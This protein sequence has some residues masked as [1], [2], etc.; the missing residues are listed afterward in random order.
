[1]KK[2]I[3]FI[4]ALLAIAMMVAMV[5]VFAAEATM[6]TV[7]VEIFETEENGFEMVNESSVSVVETQQGTMYSLVELAALAGLDVTMDTG[8][9]TVF[10]SGTYLNRKYDIPCV[11]LNIGEKSYEITKQSVFDGSRITSIT[12]TQTETDMYFT[13]ASM[14]EFFPNVFVTDDGTVRV[15]KA[16]ETYP[17]FVQ[18]S[19]MMNQEEK[20]RV[21]MAMWMLYN[22]YSEGYE[23]VM[24]YAPKITPAT[25]RKVNQMCS[26]NI[27]NA[28]AV[29]MYN[30]STIYWVEDRLENMSMVL[31]AAILCHEATHFA[32][33]KQGDYGERQTV[34]NEG[35]ALYYMGQSGYEAANAEVEKLLASYTDSRNIY[36]VGGNAFRAW[37]AE[38]TAA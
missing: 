23:I 17:K 32:Q 1:M 19:S 14:Y 31:L 38:Q 18:R 37:Y 2:T 25:Q 22:T 24:K 36:T 15:L 33:Y 11:R 13:A 12:W 28:I 4:A 9:S 30:G 34:L 7:A 26:R 3:N 21:T 8:V 35:K 29:A 5:P 6:A 16:T 10:F 20:N 27:G